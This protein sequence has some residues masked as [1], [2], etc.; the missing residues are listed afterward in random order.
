MKCTKSLP[1]L[2]GK[3]FAPSA[4]L[5][6]IFAKISILIVTER[7]SFYRFPQISIQFYLKIGRA[8]IIVGAYAKFES[9]NLINRI[10]KCTSF[11]HRSSCYLAFGVPFKQ[12]S[13]ALN[14][15][16]NDFWSQEFWREK[17]C[18]GKSEER[19]SRVLRQK[20]RLLCLLL[21]CLTDLCTIIKIEERYTFI[22]KSKIFMF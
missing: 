3:F 18:G 6:K 7:L 10:R 16:D 22:S 14:K 21:L 2:P 9:S 17:M 20:D 11:N 19:E 15:L 1:R 12:R 13:V 5:C 4:T 8:L